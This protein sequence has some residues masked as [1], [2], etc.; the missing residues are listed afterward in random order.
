[1]LVEAAA[2]ICNIGNDKS[3]KDGIDCREKHKN[4]WDKW[5]IWY[6]KIP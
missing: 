2:Y 1:M 3:E 5:Y 6:A 4:N